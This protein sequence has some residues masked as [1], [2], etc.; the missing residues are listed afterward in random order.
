[1]NCPK[2]DIELLENEFGE[3][4]CEKCRFYYWSDK[5]ETEYEEYK[6]MWE[7]ID[8]DEKVEF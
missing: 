7:A 8:L 2:C 5:H 4:L 3:K 6:K 1:M